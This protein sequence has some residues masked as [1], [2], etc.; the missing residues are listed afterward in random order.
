MIKGGQQ[1]KRAQ[2]TQDCAASAA[3]TAATY[4]YYKRETGGAFI[5]KVLTARSSSGSSIVSAF[6]LVGWQSTPI[7]RFTDSEKINRAICAA[8]R[9]PLSGTRNKESSHL[10]VLRRIINT[11]AEGSKIKEESESEISEVFGLVWFGFPESDSR[12]G[13]RSRD[14]M[15]VK[16]REF[17]GL[18][19]AEQVEVLE[20]R[21]EVGPSGK[22]SL[23]TDLMGDPICRVRHCPAYVMLV[24]EFGPEREIVGLIRGCIKTVTCAKKT[25]LQ[26]Q[27]QSALCAKA[28]YILG[29]RVSPTHRRL[30]IGLKLVQ[31]LERWF[32]ENG[33]DYAYMA[34]EKENE[35]CL[36]L[37]NGKLNYSKFRTPAMLVHPV[38]AHSKR[39]RSSVRIQ[40]LEIHE[41]EAL[42]RLF[43]GTR[44]FFPQDIDSILNNKL[45]LGTWIAFPQGENWTA[46]TLTELPSSWAI[47]SVW[48]SSDVFKLQ[49]KGVSKLKYALAAATRFFDAAFPWLKIP[50]I[51]D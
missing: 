21:C 2:R 33:A 6:W 22:I 32:V 48:N 50:S 36:R 18:R 49:V 46:K 42:Y 29:L 15:D 7:Y 8:E 19:D 51:P 40:K 20:K 3:A 10:S 28:A 41:A 11:C 45:S 13:I 37:F 4:N 27:S 12:F 30:G 24:A 47:I 38:Y 9:P 1:D 34:T 26:L 25:S 43:L 17:E 35:A 23:F 39:I 31:T 16:I 44:E 14:M 5:L